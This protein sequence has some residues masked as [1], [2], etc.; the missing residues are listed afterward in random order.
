MSDKTETKETKPA[1]PEP[2]KAAEPAKQPPAPA[3]L[4]TKAALA[5]LQAI[6]THL[7]QFEGKPGY[8]AFLWREQHRL[9]TLIALMQSGIDLGPTDVA[10][11]KALMAMDVAKI[12]PRV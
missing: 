11:I 4:D 9:T 6:D 1:T 3:K 8:N 7:K 12:E 2:A 5:S 10:Q